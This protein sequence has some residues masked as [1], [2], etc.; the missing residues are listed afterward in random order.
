MQSAHNDS[1]PFTR[2]SSSIRTRTRRC[3]KKSGRTFRPS[4]SKLTVRTNRLS[5]LRKDRIFYGKQL[6]CMNI[7]ELTEIPHKTNPSSEY[8]LSPRLNKKINHTHTHTHSLGQATNEA[9]RYL[10]CMRRRKATTNLASAIYHAPGQMYNQ[11]AYASYVPYS[12]YF[13]VASFPPSLAHHLP[14]RRRLSLLQNHFVFSSPKNTAW[15]CWNL[16]GVFKPLHQTPCTFDH[17]PVKCRLC[18]ARQMLIYPIFSVRLFCFFICSYL[19]WMY[20][21]SST[22]WCEPC[23]L[24]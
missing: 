19:L 5:S 1:L 9:S 11:R 2:C 8:S 16:P 12:R 24:A 4:N 21:R 6:E 20:F 22:F 23:G 10:I 18:A 7:C 15:R 14:F 17:A 13:R 3:T